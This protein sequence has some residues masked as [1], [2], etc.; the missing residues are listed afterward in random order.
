MQVLQK[1]TYAPTTNLN[2]DHDDEQLHNF[3][4]DDDEYCKPNDVGD[5]DG[6]ISVLCA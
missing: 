6:R 1:T 2:D 5:G 4:D 3:D